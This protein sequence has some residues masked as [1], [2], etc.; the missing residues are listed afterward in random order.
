MN[1][2]LICL[3]AWFAG[4]A[5]PSLLHAQTK[6]AS[7]GLTV[8]VLQGCTAGMAD[9]GSQSFGTLDFGT[10]YNLSTAVDVVGQQDAGAIRVSCVS[11]VN[12]RVL[13]NAGLHGTVAQRQML[14]DSGNQRIDYNLYTDAMFGT[15]WDDTTGVSAT[16]NGQDQWTRVYGRVPA[17]ATP[18][19]GNYTDSVTV[20][21]IW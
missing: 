8:K 9:G 16:G 12:Y 11:G 21:V 13:M 4:L 1:R 5:L 19:A 3:L 2:S 18:P 17:Q 6:T 20:T 10:R 15:V 14:G 7:I